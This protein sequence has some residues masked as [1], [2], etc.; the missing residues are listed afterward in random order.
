MARFDFLG[1]VLG[2]APLDLIRIAPNAIDHS[3]KTSAAASQLAVATLGEPFT[4][5]GCESLA[6]DFN[7]IIILPR[8]CLLL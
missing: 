2:H 1:R 3:E 8:T 7:K 4:S 5:A 6:R